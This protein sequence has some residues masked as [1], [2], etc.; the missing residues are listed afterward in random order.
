LLIY[1]NKQSRIKKKKPKRR[2]DKNEKWERL[3]TKGSIDYITE[4]TKIVNGKTFYLINFRKGGRVNV[5][6][7][8]L[9]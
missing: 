8:M 6:M 3:S 5:V 1:L 2:K 4:L 7:K 9:N